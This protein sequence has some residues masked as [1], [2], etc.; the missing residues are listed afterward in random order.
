MKSEELRG[1]IKEIAL[2]HVS[3]T[4][5]VDEDGMTTAILSIVREAVSAVKPKE[6]IKEETGIVGGLMTLLQK[7]RIKT[8]SDYHDALMEVLK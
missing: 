3:D 6:T 8:R 5:C 4:N 1:K 7:E 2:H